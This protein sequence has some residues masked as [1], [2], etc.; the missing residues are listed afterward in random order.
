MNIFKLTKEELEKYL[1]ENID[2]KKPNELLEELIECGL[3]SEADNESKEN[4]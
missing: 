2:T 1:K 3:E 4:I